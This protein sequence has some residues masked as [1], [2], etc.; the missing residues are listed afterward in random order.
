MAADVQ[1]TGFATLSITLRSD[2]PLAGREDRRTLVVPQSVL[3]DAGKLFEQFVLR[4]SRLGRT[5]GTA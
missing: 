4:V 3:P 2:G 1:H 5:E